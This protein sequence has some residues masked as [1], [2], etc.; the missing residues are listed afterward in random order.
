MGSRA[1]SHV[2][3]GECEAAVKSSLAMCEAMDVLCC[4]LCV[5]DGYVWSLSCMCCVSAVHVW[6][7]A[8][9]ACVAAM[10]VVCSAVHSPD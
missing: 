9:H 6:A 1:G 7:Q 3:A 5:V 10:E 2:D 8:R 4:W